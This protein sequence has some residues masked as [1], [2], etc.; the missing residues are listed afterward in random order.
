[1]GITMIARKWGDAPL[2]FKNSTGFLLIAMIGFSDETDAGVIF[3]K[4][5]MRII[6]EAFPYSGKETPM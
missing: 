1:M 4:H 3:M 5:L 2:H 6:F